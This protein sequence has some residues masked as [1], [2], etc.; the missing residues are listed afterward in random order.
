MTI[1]DLQPLGGSPNP[2]VRNRKED[3]RE[4]EEQ[5]QRTDKTK[6]DGEKTDDKRKEAQTDSRSQ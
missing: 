4:D 3:R 6:T 5:K 1:S 2:S